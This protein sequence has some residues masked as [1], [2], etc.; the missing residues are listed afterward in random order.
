MGITTSAYRL[1]TGQ[2]DNAELDNGAEGT[3]AGSPPASLRS[4][5]CP[6]Q[7]DHI[8]ASTPF[9]TRALR[10][11]GAR[12]P[13]AVQPPGGASQDSRRGSQSG[14]RRSGSSGDQRQGGFQPRQGWERKLSEDGGRQRTAACPRSRRQRPHVVALPHLRLPGLGRWRI[15]GVAGSAAFTLS[16]TPE[17]VVVRWAAQGKQPG[18]PGRAAA[19]RG[20][21]GPA[22]RLGGASADPLGGAQLGRIA[23]CTSREGTGAGLV[24]PQ[25]PWPSSSGAATVSAGGQP[26]LSGVQVSRRQAAPRRQVQAEVGDRAAAHLVRESG[27]Q[28]PHRQYPDQICSPGSPALAAR[29]LARVERSRS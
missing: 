6:P 27:G 18:A 8:P 25:P 12:R 29:P 16:V 28:I 11:A 10:Q 9:L 13:R 23:G 24:Q 19:S 15:D 1:R 14:L 4:T 17:R 2:P 3:T 22:A 21:H 20:Q 7:L 26:V 5:F